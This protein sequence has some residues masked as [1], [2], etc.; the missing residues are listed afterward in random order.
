MNWRALSSKNYKKLSLSTQH[1]TAAA[2]C[3]RSGYTIQIAYSIV[4][5]NQFMI[6]IPNGNSTVNNNRGQGKRFPQFGRKNQSDRAQRMSLTAQTKKPAH[7]IACTVR[8][9]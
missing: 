5:R 7:S 4:E 3:D 9:C 6:E 2:A 8:L 1:G